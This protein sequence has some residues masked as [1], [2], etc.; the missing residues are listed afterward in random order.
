MADSELKTSILSLLDGESGPLTKG[1]LSQILGGELGLSFTDA[2]LDT[3]L[4]ELVDSG[5]VHQEDESY[6][7]RDKPRSLP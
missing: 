4:A 7:L 1:D 3:A 6:Y 2:E 5:N